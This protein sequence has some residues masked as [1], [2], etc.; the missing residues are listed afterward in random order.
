MT[1]C[2]VVFFLRR[3]E[4]KEAMQTMSFT[5]QTAFQALLD[6]VK[7]GVTESIHQ[8]FAVC[9]VL[10]VLTLVVVL[11]L[12]EVPLRSKLHQEGQEEGESAGG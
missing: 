6:A 8:G 7:V 4:R 12:K 5:E 9:L 11:F 3:E 1:V 2:P 10:M